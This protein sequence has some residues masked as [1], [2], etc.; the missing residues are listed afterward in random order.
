MFHYLIFLFLLVV[1][2]CYSMMKNTCNSSNSLNS[3][4]LLW[5]MDPA[6]YLQAQQRVLGWLNNIRQDN[7]DVGSYCC[8]NSSHF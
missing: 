6:S 5:N 2:P 3:E 1:T 7:Q 8:I 4:S